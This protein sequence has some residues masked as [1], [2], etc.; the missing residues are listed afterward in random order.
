[1]SQFEV[2]HYAM[3]NAYSYPNTGRLVELITDIGEQNLGEEFGLKRI[4]RV[5]PIDTRRRLLTRQTPYPGKI[6][7]DVYYLPQDWLLPITIDDPDLDMFLLVWAQDELYYRAG[8]SA[9]ES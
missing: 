2:G 5:K 6:H 7:P 4:W 9:D 8:D 1:M 3:I